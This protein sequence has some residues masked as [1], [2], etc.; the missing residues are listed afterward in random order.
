MNINKW[1]LGG[2]FV[3]LVY[4]LVLMLGAINVIPINWDFFEGFSWATGIWYVIFGLI[5][6]HI[7]KEI[8]KI[9]NAKNENLKKTLPKKAEIIDPWSG[10]ELCKEG[11]LTYEM[12]IS[13]SEDQSIKG[14]IN[15]AKFLSWVYSS[16]PEHLRDSRKSLLMN[17]RAALLGDEES[18]D[19]YVAIEKIMAQYDVMTPEQRKSWTSK[20]IAKAKEMQAN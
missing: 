13:I 14:D 6:T 8:R 1:Q 12:L 19:E 10:I 9:S 2:L 11:K 3:F 4:M 17:K 18:L 20:K 7:S 15:S 5:L 16:G